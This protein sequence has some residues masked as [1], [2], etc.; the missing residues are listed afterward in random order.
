MEIVEHQQLRQVG[1][2][3]GLLKAQEPLAVAL[4]MLVILGF[5]VA[6]K[7]LVALVVV[8]APVALVAVK[9][10]LGLNNL[11]NCSKLCFS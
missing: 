11:N 3:L 2:T 7:V 10:A 5:L 4:L 9:V 8:K 1:Q 6:V